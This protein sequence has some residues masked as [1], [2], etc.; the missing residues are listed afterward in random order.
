MTATESQA[1]PVTVHF[2][3]NLKPLEIVDGPS[4]LGYLFSIARAP[5]SAD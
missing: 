3:P 2:G 1:D 5:A 4:A